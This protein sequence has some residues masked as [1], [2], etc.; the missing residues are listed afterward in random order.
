MYPDDLFTAEIVLLVASEQV[1]F[2]VLWLS[3]RA[4]H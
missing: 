3:G 1:I 4:L 2:S